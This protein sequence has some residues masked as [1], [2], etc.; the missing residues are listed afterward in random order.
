MKKMKLIISMSILFT[1]TSA[2]AIESCWEASDPVGCA[3]QCAVMGEGN[4]PCPV[5]S[6]SK[7]KISIEIRLPSSKTEEY[8]KV[9]ESLVSQIKKAGLKKRGKPLTDVSLKQICSSKELLSVVKETKLEDPKGLMEK[10]FIKIKK[11]REAKNQASVMKD[12]KH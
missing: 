11:A 5:G 10:C 3:I 6:A 7:G 2:I 8:K 12:K 9:K 1:S 4:Y